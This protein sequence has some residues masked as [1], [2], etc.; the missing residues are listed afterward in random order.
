MIALPTGAGDSACLNWPE[1]GKMTE[2]N[3]NFVDEK[4]HFGSV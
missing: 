2:F 3:P 4:G 1:R